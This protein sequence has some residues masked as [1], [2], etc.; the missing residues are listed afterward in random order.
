MDP[1]QLHYR[2][3]NVRVAVDPCQADVRMDPVPAR[4]PTTTAEANYSAKVAQ[5]TEP[6]CVCMCVRAC[7]CVCVCLCVFVRVCACLCVR[8]CVR[9]WHAHFRMNIWG[10]AC[11]CTSI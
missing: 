6:S 8:I 4:Q 5:S 7:A 3:F 9:K 10:F 1:P 11:Q 2:C